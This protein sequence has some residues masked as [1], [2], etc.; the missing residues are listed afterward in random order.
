LRKI[1]SLAAVT[2]LVAATVSGCSSTDSGALDAP[3]VCKHYVTGS[4]ANQISGKVPT[5]GLPTLDFKKGLSTTSTQSKEIVEGK[6]PRFGGNQQVRFDYAMYDAATGAKLQGNSWDGS[7][8]VTQV[9]SAPA[10]GDTGADFCSALSGSREGST[11]AVVFSAKDSHKSKAIPS[12]GIGANDSIIFVFKLDKVYLPHA[13]GTAKPAQDGFPQVVTDSKGVPGLVMQ[14]WSTSAAPKDFKSEV[15]VEGKG[16][17]LKEND[18]VTVHYSGFIWSPS[19]TQF[20]SSW[21]KGTPATFQL[22]SGSLIPGF[23]K[24]LVGQHV[25]SQV[26]AVLPPSFG[27]GNQ[28]SGSIPANSTLIFVID[29]LAAGK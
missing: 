24:A 3:L 27:Y 13:I 20:D 15:L 29:I 25:G 19:K 10:K 26:V 9:L 23:I 7:D 18:Y 6:G 5:K 16:P 2:L 28:A 8:S 12:A 14:D 1:F 4:A 17:V 21:T 22:K 11:V